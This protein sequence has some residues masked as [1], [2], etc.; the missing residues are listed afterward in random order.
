MSPLRPVIYKDGSEEII[1]NPALFPDSHDKTMRI[2]RV[3]EPIG[4]LR[5]ALFEPVS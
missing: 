2:E 4:R 1:S 3:E 5:K